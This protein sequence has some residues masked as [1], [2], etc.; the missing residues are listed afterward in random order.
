MFESHF[1]SFGMPKPSCS[2]KSSPPFAGTDLAPSL[3][4]LVQRRLILEPNLMRNGSNEKLGV[5]QHCLV[6]CLHF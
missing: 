2:P 3:E 4:M 5:C 6:P 1:C